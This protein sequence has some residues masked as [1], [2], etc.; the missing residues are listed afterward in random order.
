MKDYKVHSYYWLQV[1]SS[2]SHISYKTGHM[3]D[4]WL[5]KLIYSV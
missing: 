4:S 5:L 1:L 3:V 2:E